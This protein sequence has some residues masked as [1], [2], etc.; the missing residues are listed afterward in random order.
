MG[1]RWNARSRDGR[2]APVQRLLLRPAEFQTEFVRHLQ[3][4]ERGAQEIRR[5]HWRLHDVGLK[6]E[7]SSLQ[8]QQEVGRDHRD[9]ADMECTSDEG[10]AHSTISQWRQRLGAVSN[11]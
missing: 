9:S 11:V 10:L 1:S 4:E 3:E 2:S 6:G 7:G 8:D 5:R